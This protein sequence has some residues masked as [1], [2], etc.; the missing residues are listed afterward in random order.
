MRDELRTA[1]KRVESKRDALMAEPEVR[2][3]LMLE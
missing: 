3:E 2:E 1:V